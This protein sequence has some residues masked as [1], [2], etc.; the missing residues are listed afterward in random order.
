[1]AVTRLGRFVVGAPEVAVLGPDGAAMA[2]GAGGWSH[3]A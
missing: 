2:L 1:V 3:F